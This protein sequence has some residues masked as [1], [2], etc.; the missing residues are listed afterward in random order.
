MSDEYHEKMKGKTVEEHKQYQRELYN[1]LLKYYDLDKPLPVRVVLRAFKA[2]TLRFGEA[3]TMST[4][5]YTRYAR[6]NSRK[7]IDI[8]YEAF[9]P[10]LILF[11]STTVLCA[12]ISIVLGIIKARYS[13]SL[14]D[15]FTTMC[16]M[17]FSATPAWWVAG[18]LVLIFVYKLDI[19]PFGSMYSSPPPEGEFA[20]FVDRLKHIILPVVSVILV[21]F[22]KNAY[23]IKNLVLL[24]LQEDYVTAA[25]GR[26]I[27]EKR[28]LF[29]HVLRTSSPAI[30][31][32]SVLVI[33]LSFG[34]NIILEQ[35]LAW[36]GIGMLLW[37]AIRSNDVPVMMGILTIMTVL[38]VLAIIIIDIIHGFL[39]PR[40][41]H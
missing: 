7:V 12:I 26:G 18:V 11:I 25:R 35:I 1:S 29:G 28:I 33:V 30:V 14:L 5:Q 2:A 20:L 38:Y 10:T 9:P 32:M 36:P 4:P 22:W 15:K 17:V 40:I 16:T 3:K 37:Q 24:P 27:P 39:D 31:N 13:G 34:G 23:L 6:G 8:I 21:T 19:L 41:K